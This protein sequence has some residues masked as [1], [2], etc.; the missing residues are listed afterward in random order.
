MLQWGGGRYWHKRG[1]ERWRRKRTKWRGMPAR[2]TQLVNKK[3]F[4][5]NHAINFTT[6]HPNPNNGLKKTTKCFENT[7]TAYRVRQDTT[8][9]W[10]ARI[11]GQIQIWIRHWL[12]ILAFFLTSAPTRLWTASAYR[13]LPIPTRF[14]SSP[15]KP[16]GAASTL[17]FGLRLW[18]FEPVA[19]NQS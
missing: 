8:A 17:N 12:L 1:R 2:T 19:N 11:R 4:H 6:M 14:R 3:A 15:S 9:D 13:C 18:P 5:D 10:L 7:Q 16:F